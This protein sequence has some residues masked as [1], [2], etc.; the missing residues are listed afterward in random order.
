MCGGGRPASAKLRRGL[1]TGV[2]RRKVR[3]GGKGHARCNCCRGSF[4]FSYAPFD[5][6]GP[7]PSAHI[8]PPLLADSFRCFPSNSSLTPLSATFIAWESNFAIIDSSTS[9]EFSSYCCPLLAHQIFVSERCE[10]FTP[11]LADFPETKVGM[12]QQFFKRS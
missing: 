7:A 9:G 10:T 4:P 1:V 8:A 5:S 6:L 11:N 12:F 2:R 3:T